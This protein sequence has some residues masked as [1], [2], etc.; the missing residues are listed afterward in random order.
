MQQSQ[1]SRAKIL[2]VYA[3]SQTYTST[4]YEHL[5]SFRNYSK[6]SWYYL[7]CSQFNKYF[8]NLED[9]D[10][11][12]LHYSVRLAFAQV[13]EH[14]LESLRKFHGFR[15]L[16]I[17]DEYDNTNEVKQLINS[18]PF[19]LVFS[20]V[21]DAS[22]VKIYPPNEFSRTRFVNNFTGYVPNDLIFKLGNITPPSKRSLVVAYRGRSL[23]VRYGRLG[24]EKKS[25]GEHV[26]NYCLMQGVS[27]DI[28]WDETSRIYGDDWYKFIS[29][30]KSMLGSESGSNVFDWDGNLQMTINNYYAESPNATIQDVIRDIIEPREVHGLMNQISPRIFEMAAAKTVMVLFEGAYSGVLEPN[31]HFLPLKKDFSNLPQIF[32]TLADD[33]KVDA[34]AERAYE[35]IIIS[36][37]YGYRQF[38][39]MVDGEIGKIIA[40]LNLNLTDTEIALTD[41]L[42]KITHFPIKSKPPLPPS[43]M[44]SKF[45][46]APL[47]SYLI[48]A[49]WQRIPI[50]IR[51][52]IKRLMGRNI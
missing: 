34:I 52:Y 44:R 37:R 32:S 43:L 24:Q 5:D 14:G 42:S 15:G 12:F 4:V 18:I 36:E 1:N 19:N 27:C 17:Q 47:I 23:P 20:V 51:P 50:V 26:L 31:I 35:D 38:V 28:K 11:I 46:L 30:A 45:P 49:A 8:V 29:S 40:D 33:I 48:I 22:L 25:I 39:E 10:A 9:F 13:S 7:D 41:T 2:C 21:P 6:H 16:F 3:A